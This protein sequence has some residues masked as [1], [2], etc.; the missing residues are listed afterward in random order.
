MEE[1]FVMRRRLFDCRVDKTCFHCN[2]KVSKLF[3][4]G[5]LMNQVDP[6]SSSLA[7]Q[8]FK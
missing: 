1:L 2:N 5:A 7:T 8:P 6:I 3:V 4:L